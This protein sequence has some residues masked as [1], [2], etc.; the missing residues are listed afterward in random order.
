MV[1]VQR[2]SYCCLHDL[3]RSVLYSALECHTDLAYVASSKQ[4]QIQVNPSPGFKT[5]TLDYRD[6]HYNR[7]GR[8]IS[9]HQH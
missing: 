5:Y 2:Y 7:C 9:V 3:L 1:D 6:G 8:S 4:C